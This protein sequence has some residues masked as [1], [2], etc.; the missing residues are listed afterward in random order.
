MK[1]DP[2]ISLGTLLSAVS[3]IVAV[4]IFVYGMKPRIEGLE[5]QAKK[6]LEREKEHAEL[7]RG[8]D[9]AIKELAISVK[10]LATLQRGTQERME[11]MDNRFD[12]FIDTVLTRKSDG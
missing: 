9:A 6:S 7:A 11:R 4:I 8:R 3:F 5:D 2:S 10:E 1:F 12:K